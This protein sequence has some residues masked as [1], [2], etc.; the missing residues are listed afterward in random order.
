MRFGMRSGFFVGTALALA[1]S[2]PAFAVNT[3]I[4]GKI[5]IIKTGK[6][7]KMVSKG[8]FP[9]LP[10]PGGGSDPSVAGGQLDVFDTGSGQAFSTAL[11]S[12][13]WKGLGNPAGSKGYKYKGAGS[14]GD[15]CKVVVYKEKVIKFVCKD[16]QGLLPPLVTSSGIILQTGADGVCA[17]FGGTVIKNVADLYKAK[18]APAPA[19]C[20]TPGS[21]GGSTTTFPPGPCCNGDGFVSFATTT[22]P[23]DCGDIINANGMTI[24]NIAC[25]GLY[26]GG[27]GNSV[28]LPLSIPDLGL[29]VN[30]ITSCT[31]QTATLGPTTSSQT[32]SNRSCTSPGCLF[33]AP[34][35][36]PNPTSIATSTC[37][38]NRVAT[39]TSGTLNCFTGETSASLPLNSEVF[40]TGDLINDPAGTIPGIQ[41][42][43]LCSSST[44]IGGPN[45]GMSCTPGT[46]A[47]PGGS[48]PTS[49]DCPPTPSAAISTL[50]IGFALSSGTV[51]W[52]ASTPTNPGS[53]QAR[54]FSGFCRDNP[55]SGGFA[56]PAQ[57]CWE[58]G[59]AIGACAG[60]FDSC[61]QREEGAFGPNGSN[62]QTIVAIGNG[63][64]ILGGPAAGTLVS[65]FTIPPT[66]NPTVDAAGSLPGP[67]AVAI[68]GTADLCAAASPCP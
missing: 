29:A 20:P 41:T 64:N 19:V 34:L 10:T 21:G 56:Q 23:G 39:G 1:C 38:L 26:I 47:L 36:V 12:A 61:E 14:G 62:F 22:T 68:P 28:P 32:T 48:Y 33:G 60:T 17:E 45:N 15:P 37:T 2:V 42:C 30:A 24:N 46:S 16:S 50:P 31:G 7:V 67:G 25:S 27:G 13:G 3:P 52:S 53:T 5:H 44:C 51:T 55:G 8:P 57:P 63:A 54:V 65:I 66:Y 35:A 11:L 18:D 59:M 43:P 49:H 40:L 58:N 4:S 9:A 6:L